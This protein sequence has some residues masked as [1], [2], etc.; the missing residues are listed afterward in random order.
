MVLPSDEERL[1]LDKRIGKNKKFGI[2]KD[3]IGKIELWRELM[4]DMILISLDSTISE[5]NP[6]TLIDYLEDE[7]GCTPER[8]FERLSLKDILEKWLDSLKP[9]QEQCIR[10]YFGL[11]NIFGIKGPLSLEEIG[12]IYGVT[13]ERIRQIIK[14]GIIKLRKRFIKNNTKIEDYIA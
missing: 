11:E 6:D 9:Q 12:D 5:D 3:T 14:H 4:R 13:R 10:I 1:I 2:P 8:E 7:G